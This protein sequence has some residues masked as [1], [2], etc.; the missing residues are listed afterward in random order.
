MMAAATSVADFIVDGILQTAGRDKWQACCSADREWSCRT[1]V[2]DPSLHEL[3]HKLSRE[4]S[5]FRG[6]ARSQMVAL[7]HDH[8]LWHIT[9]LTVLP[10]E[11][12]A[13]S[14]QILFTFWV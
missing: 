11:S 5:V 14:R 2:W 4:A 13:S 7:V 1:T 6:Y 3:N 8:R 10:M 9:L 12:G